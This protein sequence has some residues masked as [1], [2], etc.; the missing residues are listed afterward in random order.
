MVKKVNKNVTV[1]VIW[2]TP[3]H[4]N[5]IERQPNE[6]FT[7]ENVESPEIATLIYHKYLI[8]S[9]QV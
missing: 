5:G 4:V 7:V 9:T 1:T 6:S 8:I 2:D 3:I